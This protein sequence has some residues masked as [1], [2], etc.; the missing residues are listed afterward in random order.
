VDLFEYQGKDF[1]RRFG[2]PTSTGRVARDKEAAAQA[3]V[4][5]GFPAVI[6]AQV[7]VGGRGKAGGVKLVTTVEEAREVA[8]RIL[9]MDIKGHTVHKVWVE[10]AS[11]IAKEYYVS[12]TLDRGAKQYLCLLSAEGGVEIEEVAATNPGAIARAHIDPIDGFPE[13]ASRALVEEARLDPAVTDQLVE[14]LGKLYEAFVKG[15]ADLVEVNP[16]IVTADGRV[17]ALDA[18]VSLDDSAAFRHPEWEAYREEMELDGREALARSKGLNYIGLDGEVG[19]IANGAGLAMATL[20]VVHQV[21]GQAANFLDL[22]GGAGAETMANALEVI[23]T[24][25]KV[26]SVLV[27]IFG[28]IT[29]CDEVAKGIEEALGRVT[30][31]F[32]MVI[33]LDGTNAAEGREILDRLV[34]DRVRVEATMVGAAKVAVAL[35]G[36]GHA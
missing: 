14:V 28:G 5:V 35:A 9:G 16:L 19:I 26:R 12:F 17:H 18:K 11:D 20:D 10:R 34:S 2:V 33:R 24:D 13:D 25:E 7:Q 4:E 29:R 22:G 3:A 32:P 31:R 8:G 27:N 23:N 15:D 36:E 1:F 21:G 30:L 6:K